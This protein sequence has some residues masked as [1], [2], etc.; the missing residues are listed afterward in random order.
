M[1]DM[2]EAVI[3]AS[4]RRVSFDPDALDYF[5]RAEALG[6]S[7]DQTAINPTYGEAYV[8]GAISDMIAGLKAD[9]VWSKIPEL[10][11]LAGVSF[12]GLMAK[13]KHAGTPVLTNVS[14]NF[15]A[16]DYLAAGSGAGLNKTANG[17][18]LSTGETAG[19]LGIQVASSSSASVYL[20]GRTTE[21]AWLMPNAFTS[22][23]GILGTNYRSGS[24]GAIVFSSITGFRVGA[25]IGDVVTGYTNGTTTGSYTQV[26]SNTSNGTLTLFEYA[27]NTTDNPRGRITAAHIGT[28]LTD[29]EATNLSLRINALMTALGCNVYNNP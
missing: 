11:L 1:I 24:N 18:K 23:L 12:G 4:R 21:G 25:R 5:S 14:N 22:Q 2:M 7:F 15:V 26:G 27:N 17:Q 13:V 6:G 10:Y 3:A 8:K 9:A 16:A 20:T 28:G 19:T 29:T